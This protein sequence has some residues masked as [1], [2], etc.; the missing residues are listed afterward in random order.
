[1]LTETRRDQIRDELIGEIQGGVCKDSMQIFDE[2]I[3]DGFMTADEF[4][5]NE[6]EICY[7]FD[8]GFFT[9]AL[10]GW[11]MPNDMTCIADVEEATCSDCYCEE[12][13]E[14]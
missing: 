11:T 5:M 13:D 6:L 4:R 3:D 7:I 1:M 2:W 10:C 14:D 8:D 9:C 12:N